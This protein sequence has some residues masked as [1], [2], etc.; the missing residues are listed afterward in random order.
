MRLIPIIC[1]K[2]DMSI[3]GLAFG[4]GRKPK[5]QQAL[6]LA[7]INSIHFHIYA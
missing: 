7:T 1:E 3:R 4:E 6:L 5:I 2:L